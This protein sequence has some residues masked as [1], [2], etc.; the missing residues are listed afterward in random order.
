MQV[1]GAT[2]NLP[3]EERRL[4]D[5]AEYALRTGTTRLRTETPESALQLQRLIEEA[6]ATLPP[7]RLKVYFANLLTL[8]GELEWAKEQVAPIRKLLEAG[9]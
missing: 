5:L 7:E 9:S 8:Y 1:F 4:V 6:Q 3:R 2:K